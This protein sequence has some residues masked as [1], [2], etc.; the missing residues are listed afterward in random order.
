M[1]SYLFLQSSCHLVPS[2]SERTDIIIKKPKM[3]FGY[4]VGDILATL[5]LADELKKRFTQAPSEF[6]AISG[7]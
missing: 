7:E 1:S 4:G 6:K 3:S 5:K 2:Q